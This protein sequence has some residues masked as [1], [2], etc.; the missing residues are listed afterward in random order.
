MHQH[1]GAAQ[2][3]GFVT[4]SA[5]LAGT[6]GPSNTLLTSIGARS[7]VRRGMTSLLGQVTGMGAMLFAIA[8]GL[9]N[10]LLRHPAVLQAL[11]WG[12]IAL[13]CWLAWRIATAQ[14][15]TATTRTR[16]GF[17]AMAAFQL[18]NPKGWLTGIAA[19]GTVLSS[20]GGS[21]LGQAALFAMVF[22]ATAFVSCFPWLAAGAAVQR[23]LRTPRTRRVFNGV[24]GALLAASAMLLIWTHV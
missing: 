2:L 14:Q 4:F 5:V 24:M 22:T 13:L 15:V 12:S 23:Y 1:Y 16:S 21:A 7:G 8:L 20:H 9:A 17:L 10:V 18:I 11:K 19:V 3:I 6:P